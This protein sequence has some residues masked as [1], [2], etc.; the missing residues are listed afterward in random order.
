[1]DEQARHKHNVRISDTLWELIN[2][3]YRTSD[4]LRPPHGAINMLLA[5]GFIAHTLHNALL[6]VRSEYVDKDGTSGSHN[7]SIWVYDD[8]W[9][10]IASSLGSKKYDG[11]YDIREEDINLLL[12]IG[13][14]TMT[15]GADI[16][17]RTKDECLTE[18]SLTR[19]F[20]T[21]NS[22][23]SQTAR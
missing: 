10:L 3:R 5:T 18:R 2:D 20:T 8:L 23:D 17:R 21:G 15:K 16:L 9:M 1:M 19:V 11:S 13:F 14:V 6:D 7:R 12:S 4:A 22:P